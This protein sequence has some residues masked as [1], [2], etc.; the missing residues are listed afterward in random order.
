MSRS[1][2]GWA[3]AHGLELQPI[4]APVPI[5]AGDAWLCQAWPSGHRLRRQ[6]LDKGQRPGTR[7]TVRST[8]RRGWIT[9]FHPLVF[10]KRRLSFVLAVA[11]GFHLALSFIRSTDK[12]LITSTSAISVSITCMASLPRFRLQYCFVYTRTCV[13]GSRLGRT[14]GLLPCNSR[15]PLTRSIV[16]VV[17]S[18]GSRSTKSTSPP[19][20]LTMSPPPTSSCL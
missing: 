1:A 18:P 4:G 13:N 19:W 16:A 9:H 14:L 20:R 2:R 15:A 7:S 10:Q 12:K 5:V 6:G 11:S 8:V 17:R 3:R